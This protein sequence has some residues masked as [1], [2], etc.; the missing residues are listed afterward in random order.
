MGFSAGGHTKRVAAWPEGQRPCKLCL[1]FKNY[2]DFHKHSAMP[3]GVNNVC[4]ECRK[5]LSKLVRDKTSDEY[6]LFHA[7]KNRAKVKGLPFNLEIEDISIPAVCPVFGKAFVK[8]DHKRAASLDRKIPE[9]GYVKGNVWI[10]SNQA[11]MMKGEATVEELKAFA[12]WVSE[13]R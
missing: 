4:R 9:L 1:V 2:E 13:L 11:N 3:F 6:K 12:R 7:A 5:P 10:I 8:G